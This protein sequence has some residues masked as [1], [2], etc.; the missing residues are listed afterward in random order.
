MIPLNDTAF[1]RT[2]TSMDID[3]SREPFSEYVVIKTDTGSSEELEP[4]EARTWFLEHGA[5]MD[6]VDKM[7]DYV[8]NFGSAKISI[9]NYRIPKRH[10]HALAPDV[11]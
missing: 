6:V 7:L 5:D 10:P 1:V 2:G 9:A 8:W 4:E 3:V 11:P